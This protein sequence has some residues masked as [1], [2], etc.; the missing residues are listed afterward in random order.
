MKNLKVPRSIKKYLEVCGVPASAVA[1]ISGWVG[2]WV[3]EV[4]KCW[5]TG[6]HRLPRGER[7]THKVVIHQLRRHR[8]KATLEMFLIDV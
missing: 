5:G 8:N 6:A 7:R 3:G 1:I 2:G 4:W